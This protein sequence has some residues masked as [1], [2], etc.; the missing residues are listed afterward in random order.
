M[1]I[2]ERECESDRRVVAKA[3]LGSSVVMAAELRAEWWSHP[4]RARKLMMA[5]G[6]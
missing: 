3:T 6:S 4:M 2:S 1:K 5:S